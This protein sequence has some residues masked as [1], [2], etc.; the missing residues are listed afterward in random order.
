MMIFDVLLNIKTFVS[1]C[2]ERSS[3]G[4][5]RVKLGGGGLGLSHLRLN[6]MKAFDVCLNILETQ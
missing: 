4:G 1:R 5:G 2:I 3:W 6:N